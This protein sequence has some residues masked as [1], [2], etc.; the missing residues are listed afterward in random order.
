MN[1]VRRDGSTDGLQSVARATLDRA[2]E[3]F[4][5]GANPFAARRQL[6]DAY[7]LAEKC[8]ASDI[9]AECRDTADSW[10]VSLQ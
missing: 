10:G 1:F 4:E 2:V 3:R 6:Q 8:G 5:I 9:V 7:Q